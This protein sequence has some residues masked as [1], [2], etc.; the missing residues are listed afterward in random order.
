MVDEVEAAREALLEEI[1][2]HDDDLMEKY[3]GWRRADP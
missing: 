2:S 3:L 1:S